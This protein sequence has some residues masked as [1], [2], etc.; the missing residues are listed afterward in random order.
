MKATKITA[1]D[2]P[3]DQTSIPKSAFAYREDIISVELPE[4]IT[5]IEDYAFKQCKN[6]ETVILPKSM[7]AIGVAAFCGCSKLQKIIIPEGVSVIEDLCFALCSNLREVS[8]P[9]TVTTLRPQAFREC[10]ALW[11]LELPGGLE[12]I[13]AHCFDGCGSL[14]YLNFPES[15]KKAEPY[16][17][18]DTPLPF[19]HFSDYKHEE[20][21]IMDNKKYIP[22]PIDT[23]DVNLSPEIY[24]LVEKLAENT[25]DVWAAQRI[26]QGW[27][28]GYKRDDYRKETPCLVPYNELPEEEKEYDRQT[29]MEAIKVIVKLGFNITNKEKENDQ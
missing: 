11:E 15:L 17:F 26:S 3:A 16:A 25:H 27:T 9:S 6:L 23:S 1:A 19:V 7:K 20:E 8:I 2:F 14:S 24:E 21:L 28:Y 10:T 22:N 29:A 4:T 12:V 18:Y 5:E 13:G